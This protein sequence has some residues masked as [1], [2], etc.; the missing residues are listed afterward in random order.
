[1]ISRDRAMQAREN[2]YLAIKAARVHTKACPKCTRRKLGC[3]EGQ[4]LETTAVLAAREAKDAL[5]QYAPA[6]TSVTYQGT[7]PGMNGQYTV[8][9]PGLRAT[10]ATYHLI[11]DQ[12]RQ[13]E[14][15]SL[16]AIEL[17][18]AEAAMRDRVAAVRE[19]VAAVSQV[20]QACGMELPIQVDQ[21]GQR[22]VFVSWSPAAFVEHGRTVEQMEIGARRQYAE[23]ALGLL[24]GLRVASRADLQTE[25]GRTTRSA[26]AIMRQLTL[27]NRRA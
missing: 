6:G 20:L 12:G 1:M 25:V 2:A 17:T 4:Q 11:D 21:V 5:S 16:P 7:T 18:D 27:R 23:S 13:V 15:A 19:A 26:Q 10:W 8:N 14:A 22:G 24:E 3:P 9:G